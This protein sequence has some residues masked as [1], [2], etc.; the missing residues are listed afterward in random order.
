[1]NTI[2]M[3]PSQTARGQVGVEARF[4]LRVAS[5]LNQQSRA[6]PHDISE[7]LRHSRELALER[8]RATRRSQGTV[9]VSQRGVGVLA[10][11]PSWLLGLGSIMPLLLLLAGLVLIDEWED[12]SQVLAAAD[13]DSA[14][15]ADELPPGAYTDAGF[16]EFLRA[17]HD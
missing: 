14:L 5:A 1:M 17:G 4:G 8:A 15:L 10:R 13:V 16:I 2:T 7:R 9:A 11:R 12:R 3:K 6:A